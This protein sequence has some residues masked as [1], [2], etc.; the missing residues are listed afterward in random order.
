VG[1]PHKICLGDFGLE[2]HRRGEIEIMRDIL[3]CCLKGA[4]KT[5][6]V[7]SSNLNFSRLEKYLELLLNLGFISV[8]DEPEKNIAYKTTE[9]GINFIN[10]FSK[11]RKSLEQEPNRE[12]KGKV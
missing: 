10:G 5:K 12:N 6:I 1:F 2:G 4:A 7:Y 8:V 11:M 9:A 3:E